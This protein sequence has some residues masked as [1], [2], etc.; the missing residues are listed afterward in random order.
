MTI[1]TDTARLMD[2]PGRI[3]TIRQIVETVADGVGPLLDLY[4]PYVDGLQHLPRDGRFLLVGNHTQSGAEGFLIPYLVRRE[5]GTLVRPLTDR[6]FGK[7]PGPAADLLAA[8]GATVGAPEAAHELMRHN[9]PILVFPGGGREIAKFKG[10]E[11]SLRWQGR[12]GFARIAAE[13]DY[14]IVPAGL[15]GGDD[16]YRSLT[17]RDGRW[18]RLSQAL[19]KALGAP[20]DMAMP[21]L[22]GIGP[23]L[24]PRPQRMYLRF[25]EPIDTTRPAGVSAPDWADTV[26][27][28]TQTALEAVLADVQ[29]IRAGDPYRELNPLA[30]RD[31]VRP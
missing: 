20:D 12:T 16:V 18:G 8:C 26:K 4:R 11:Y 5:I 28:R 6:G 31:A 13:H 7:M 22:H 17:T 29:E 24:I 30:W 2:Q 19:A 23:T 14:P 10:E 15:I 27:H 25:A 3:Q 1:M 9:Q 21:L